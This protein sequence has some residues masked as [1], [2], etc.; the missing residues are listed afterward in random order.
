[1]SRAIETI[2][3]I[4]EDFSISL[5]DITGLHEDKLYVVSHNGHFAFKTNDLTKA[6]A[7]YN[8]VKDMW[9]EF[10]RRVAKSLA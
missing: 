8:A 5:L 1:M 3:E 4:N 6:K 10:K 9:E 7:K 2:K